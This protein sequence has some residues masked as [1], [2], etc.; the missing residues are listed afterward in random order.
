MRHLLL[1]LTALQ[2]LLPEITGQEWI[3][4]DNKKGKLNTFK[5]DDNTR[6]SGEK[7]Y[8]VNCMSCH[9]IP[10]KANYLNLFPPPGDPATEKIQRNKDGEIFYKVTTGRGQ[11][12][13]FRSV[14]S[15]NEIWYI[16][17]FL[18][19]FN[20]TYKQEI[21]QVIT[22]SAYPGAVINILL[23]F[24]NSDSTIV[25]NASAV[26]DKNVVP[27]TGAE[28]KLHVRRTFGLLPVDET[29][30]TDKDGIASFSVPNNLTGD[31]AGNVLVSAWFINEEIFGSVSKDTI[32]RAA[33]KTFPVSLTAQRAMWNNVRKAPIWIILTYGLGLLTSWGFIFYVLM[34]LRDIFIIGEIVTTDTLQKK[35]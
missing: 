15:S 25:L 7:L 24:N 1:V 2:L 9:G 18:R 22:S 29:K 26:K 32:L 5:F 27:V 34:K 4:P 31:T 11:M 19:S 33:G 13:S 28:V 14:L 16:I 10:G 35:N 20:H 12:P 6:K 23:S 3:V 8:S 30:T 21:M 17:S